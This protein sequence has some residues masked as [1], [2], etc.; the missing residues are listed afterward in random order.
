MNLFILFLESTEDG[1]S[2]TALV[3]QTQAIDN[4]IQVYKVIQLLFI[5]LI[6]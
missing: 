6:I 5:I 4:I 1:D 2:P 3:V